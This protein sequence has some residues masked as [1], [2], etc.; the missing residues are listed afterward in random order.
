MR[1]RAARLLLVVALGSALGVS[2]G[3]GDSGGGGGGGGGGSTVTKDF[4]LVNATEKDFS[5]SLDSSSVPAGNVAFSLTNNGP[6]VHEFVVF[7][8]E[9]PPDKLPL[10]K[11]NGVAIVDEEAKGIEPQAELEDVDPDTQQEL[12]IQ[13]EPGNYVIICNIP[14]HYKLGMQTTLEVTE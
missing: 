7:R 8:T 5:I 6:S 13:L 14:T 11:E 12:A 1:G 9:L 2:C 3:G 4:T 10:T